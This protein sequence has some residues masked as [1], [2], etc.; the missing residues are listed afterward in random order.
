MFGLDL[1]DL[2]FV[3][4]HILCIFLLFSSPRQNVEFHIHQNLM[5]IGLSE[6]I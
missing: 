2:Y 4:C 3:F 5:E 6:V 1:S